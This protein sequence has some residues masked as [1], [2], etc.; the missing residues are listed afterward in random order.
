M[1][2]LKDIL[3]DKRRVTVL[4]SLSFLLAIFMVPYFF[5]FIP[6][7]A[8][9]IKRQAFLKLDRAAQNIISKSDDTHNYFRNINTGLNCIDSDDLSRVECSSMEIDRLPFRDSVY[10]M[11]S[12][13]GW[14]I[15]FGRPPSP[16][17]ED[18]PEPCH[19]VRVHE[20]PVPDFIAPCL[21][22]GKEVFDAFLLL[23]YCQQMGKDSNGKI[24]YQDFQTGLEQDID[25]DSLSPKHN[26]MRSPDMGDISLKGTD[27]KLF[28]YPFL[29]GQHRMVLCGL[30]KTEVYNTKLHTIPVGTS[31]TLVICLV[32]FLSACHS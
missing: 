3:P 7:N 30:M 18:F 6:A 22:S 1:A 26:G 28:T 25:L 15:L 4:V 5:V 20:L 8:D 31:Y 17:D 27:Y 29:L 12:D 23:H 24:L 32:L 21:A 11:F 13:S 9:N 19:T 10:F 16:D 2:G 14:K